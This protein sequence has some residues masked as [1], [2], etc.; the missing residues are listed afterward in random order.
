M[1]LIFCESTDESKHG[2]LTPLLIRNAHFRT[3]HGGTQL[4]LQY[5]RKR[6]WITGAGNTIKNVV[7]QCPTCFKQRMQTSTQLMASLPT[8]RTTPSRPFAKIGIDYAGPVMIR[9][10]LGRAPKLTKAWIAVFVCLVTRAI[11]LE[12]VRSASTAHFM[13]AL[14]RMIARRGMV[15]E[16]VSDNGTNFVGANIFFKN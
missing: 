10:S 8:N 6:Y 12:L 3:G 1:K 2:K 16:I 4:M 13:A 7:R 14:K 9:F 5:L 15:S 11:N